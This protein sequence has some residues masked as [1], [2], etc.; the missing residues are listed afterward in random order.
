MDLEKNEKV[1]FSCAELVP[2]LS[3]SQIVAILTQHEKGQKVVDHCQEHGI[4]QT[5]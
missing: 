4:S 2:R 3:E 5:T 1:T